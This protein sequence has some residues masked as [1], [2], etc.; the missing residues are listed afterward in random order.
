[1]SRLR[2]IF[3]NIAGGATGAG[4][5]SGFR[6]ALFV[7]T[8]SRPLPQIDQITMSPYATTPNPLKRKKK[9][10]KLNHIAVKESAEFDT[11]TTSALKDLLRNKQRDSELRDTTEVFALEDNDGAIV[12]VYV[13]KDQAEE[14]KTAIESA[15]ADEDE[16][17]KEIAEILFDLHKGF[18][19]VSVDWG[20]GSIPEDEEVTNSIDAEEQG[21]PDSEELGNPEAGKQ[22]TADD[23]SAIGDDL[24]GEFGDELGGPEA[25]VDGAV[26]QASM[27][28][29]IIGLLKSQADAQRAQA[30]AAKAKADVEAAEAAGRA[31][32]QYSSYQEEVMDMEN[33]N[34][35]SQ[36]ERRE[37]QIQAKL[38][39]YRHDLRK[40]KSQTL[41]DKLNDPE[42][43]LNT[44]HKASIGESVNI[45]PPTPE[46]EEVLHMEDWE[47]AEKEKKQNEQ[48]RQRM[49]RYKH[50]RGKAAAASAPRQES[51]TEANK[52]F[53]PKTGSLMDYLLHT[54]HADKA[55]E[56]NSANQ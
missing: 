12:K 22:G 44:L 21:F 40:D 49:L 14:F 9:I 41:D 31:A 51:Q 37:N 43:L 53:D 26:D 36:E 11:V 55:N 46:E 6:G 27:L 15:L 32:A 10:M 4:S 48:L 17:N 28:N 13:K 35:R 45:T 50:A 54:K 42:H 3:E 19:I 38:L 5:I 56:R 18:E 52:T 39:R 2:D 34:K 1:M 30:D 16:Q 25:D 7:G 23:A 20:K 29:Q 33:Y 8:T 24:G 47:K